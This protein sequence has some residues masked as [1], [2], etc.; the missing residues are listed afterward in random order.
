MTGDT[1]SLPTSLGGTSGEPIGDRKYPAGFDRQIFAAPWTTSKGARLP[2]L[3]FSQLPFF[4]GGRSI[5]SLCKR[6]A[7][8]GFREMLSKL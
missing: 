4:K 8:R 2:D 5:S 7:G 6:E 1:S 3:I